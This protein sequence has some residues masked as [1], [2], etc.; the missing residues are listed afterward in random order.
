MLAVPALGLSAFIL[1]GCTQVSEAG[2]QDGDTGE[3]T[4]VVSLAPAHGGIQGGNLVLVDTGEG[5][6]EPVTAQFGDTGVECE[7]DDKS[8]RHAC[9]VPAREVPGTVD[10]ALSTNGVPLAETTSY[11]YTTDG[12]QDMPV[13]TVDTETV[14]GHAEVVRG[15]Y[16]PGVQLGAVLKNGAP[17]DVFGQ[18][19]DEA[20]APEY[21][22]VPKLDDAIALRDAGIESKIAVM[23]VSQIED[24]PLMLHYDIEATAANL[25]W[26]EEAEEIVSQSDGTLRVH[27]WIDTGLGREGVTPDEA[28]PLARAI[29]ESENLEL[30]GIATHF[31]TITENDAEA[32]ENNDATNTTVAQKNRFDTAVA[33][34]RDAGLGQDALIHAGASD[35]L[36]NQIEPLFYDLMRIGGA[37]FGGLDVEDRVYS[38]T[39]ELEQIKTLPAGWCID[40]DCTDPTEEPMKV[41]LVNHIPRRETNVVFTIRGQEVPVV[42]HHGT[43]VTLDLSAVPDAEVGDVVDMDFD[44]NTYFMLDGTA[45][46]PVTTDW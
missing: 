30:V 6:E 45:P 39:T 44:P 38:W 17:V 3:G 11:T 32:I 4:G 2:A 43:V 41:G 10:V 46:L 15:A 31:S 25:A 27:Q 42:L 7:F 37:F 13:L 40:Y 35:V 36:Y 29:E 21:F 16:P 26:V 5:T 33:E 19:I 14:R 23:Y 1:A 28:L 9:I 8:G 18:V 34:I 24:I 20:A 22:F 12:S